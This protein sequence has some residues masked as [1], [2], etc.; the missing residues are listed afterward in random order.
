MLSPV[1]RRSWCSRFVT[2]ISLRASL[3]LIARNRLTNREGG[4]DDG[5]VGSYAGTSTRAC[6]DGR[7]AETCHMP[8]CISSGEPLVK[9]V[10]THVFFLRS[11]RCSMPT[12]ATLPYVGFDV[13][14]LPSLAG[15]QVTLIGR[16][17]VT[18]EGMSAETLA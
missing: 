7:C 17:W 8:F 1:L 12:K 14:G 15:F 2:L 3:H 11:R 4:A 13:L 16:F 10:V 6:R 18:G 5:R 9:I